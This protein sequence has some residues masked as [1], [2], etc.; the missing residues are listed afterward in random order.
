MPRLGANPT[1]DNTARKGAT[2]IVLAAPAEFQRKPRQ[3]CA[4]R[5]DSGNSD[6][7][8]AGDATRGPIPS[9]VSWTGGYYCW[10][11]RHVTVL[12]AA[13]LGDQPVLHNQW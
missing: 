13:R 9:T 10:D 12:A 2:D 11:T 4:L 5:P 6:C 8:P 3:C 7:W 1:V